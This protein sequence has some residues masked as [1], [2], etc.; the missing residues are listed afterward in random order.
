MLAK[1]ASIKST[2]AGFSA[3]FS[4]RFP[5][6]FS[7]GLSNSW[8]ISTI[9]KAISTEDVHENKKTIEIENSKKVKTDE[10]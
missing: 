3:G 4:A 5:A 8:F 2:L 9:L 1:A 10:H 7:A 6:G